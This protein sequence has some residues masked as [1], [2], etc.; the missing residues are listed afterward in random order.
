M[1]LKQELENIINADPEV[2][3]EPLWNWN[4]GITIKQKKLWTY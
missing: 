1:E 2:L 3:I 4:F